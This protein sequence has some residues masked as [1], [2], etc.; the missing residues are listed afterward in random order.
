MLIFGTGVAAWPVADPLREAWRKDVARRSVAFA[1]AAALWLIC[2]LPIGVL[3]DT[4]FSVARAQTEDTA[5]HE[6]RSNAPERQMPS[7]LG[8]FLNQNVQLNPDQEHTAKEAFHR[9]MAEC[10][11]C[12]GKTLYLASPSC[13]PSNIT[14]QEI[15]L[16][17]AAGMNQE[18]IL[19][20]IEKDHGHGALAI[21][22]VSFMRVL[23]WL[24]PI[25]VLLGGLLLAIYFVS[26]R[27]KQD[28]NDVLYTP[29]THAPAYDTDSEDAAYFA[30]LDRELKETEA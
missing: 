30:Q 21:P 23:N 12:A 9:V 7:D 8:A 25:T 27:R 2:L 14:K 4:T 18:Q 15:R 13:V 24:L 19:A 29:N 17:A 6:V 20:Q 22:Q 26:R 1:G 5:V 3:L 11:G 16:M 10:E 28:P